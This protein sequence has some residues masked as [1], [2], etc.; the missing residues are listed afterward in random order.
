MI[1]Q[2]ILIFFWKSYY[3]VTKDILGNYA[4]QYILLMYVLLKSIFYK[5]ILE[6]SVSS[7]KLAKTAPQFLVLQ[8]FGA[9]KLHIL[10]IVYRSTL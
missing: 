3:G 9:T 6:K 1:W 10:K 5:K 7:K 8:G 4:M 2:K